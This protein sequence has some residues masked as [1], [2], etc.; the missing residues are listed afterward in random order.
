[1]KILTFTSL[2]PNSITPRHG[3]FVKNRMD[4]FDRIKD[5]SRKVIAPVQYFPLLG[6]KSGSKFHTYN[7]V[8]PT[9]KQGKIPVYH[10]RYMTLPGSS[11]INPAAAMVRAADKVINTAYPSPESFDLVDGHYLYPDGIAAYQLAKKYNKPLILTARGSDVNFWLEQEAHKAAILEAIDYA[12]KTI[13]VSHA[14]K[15]RLIHHGVAEDK[16]MVIRN[17]VDKSFFDHGT[18]KGGEY[19]LTIGNLVPL[20]GHEFILQALAK[21]PEERLIIIGSGELEKTLKMLAD[22]LSISDRVTFMAPVPHRELPP[23]YGHAKFTLLMSSMEGMPNVIL[24]SLAVGTPVIATDVGGISEVVTADNGI[25]LGQRN[26]D[27]LIAAL[28]MGLSHDWDRPQI[29]KDVQYLD[30]NEAVHQL[31]DCFMQALQ[32]KD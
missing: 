19:L 2:Y 27:S 6:L 10:P 4:Y 23:L 18:N 12:S 14:L 20:K 22:D 26:A 15:Q 13:C 5:T 21:L 7:Q 29:S 11:L 31:H 1:M 24:E 8:P 32:E 9:E 30:W 25:L 28:K 3:V 16:L 17:G